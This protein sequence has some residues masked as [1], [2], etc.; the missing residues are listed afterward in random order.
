[1]ERRAWEVLHVGSII[2]SEVCADGWEPIGGY[3]EPDGEPVTIVRRRFDPPGPEAADASDEARLAA[4][5]VQQIAPSVDPATGTHRKY[6]DR[7][8][9][10]VSVDAPD[11]F[12][13]APMPAGGWRLIGAVPDGD[14][15][16]DVLW[17]RWV[18]PVSS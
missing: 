17:S 8:W 14:G 13:A 5:W 11:G 1:M 7:Q 10:A 4:G 6:I 9:V 12:G 3:R 15:D 18:R 16:H 2:A